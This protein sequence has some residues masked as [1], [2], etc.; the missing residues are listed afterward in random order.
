MDGAR[1]IRD[2]IGAQILF[3]Q[4]PFGLTVAY[5]AKPCISMKEWTLNK[6]FLEEVDHICKSRRAVFLKLELDEYEN[7]IT[8][9]KIFKQRMAN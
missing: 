4:L 9:E 6:G 8:D 1:L 7:Y 5:I 2:K 3:K